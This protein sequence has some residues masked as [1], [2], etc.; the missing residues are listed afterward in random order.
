MTQGKL[1]P[2]PE[3]QALD[4]ATEFH[5]FVD[6]ADT[7]DYKDFITEGVDVDTMFANQD[8]TDLMDVLQTL[9][10]DVAMASRFVIAIR[11]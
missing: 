11:K 10:V 8:Y 3:L 5:Q 1:T 9:G 6:G 4:D 7:A 2:D